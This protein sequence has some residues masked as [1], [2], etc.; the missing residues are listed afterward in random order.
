MSKH[1][2][3]HEKNAKLGYGLLNISTTALQVLTLTRLD[4]IFTL[5]DSMDKFRSDLQV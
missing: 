1:K 3:V 5:Y 2:K 4:K